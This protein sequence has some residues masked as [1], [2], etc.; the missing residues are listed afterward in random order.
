[1]GFGN[2]VQPS[3]RGTYKRLLCGDIWQQMVIALCHLIRFKIKIL[4]HFWLKYL[5]RRSCTCSHIYDQSIHLGMVDHNTDLS[6][7]KRTHTRRWY[8]C[9][10][11]CFCISRYPYN[12][13]QM[14]QDHTLKI[15]T[16]I[17]NFFKNRTLVTPLSFV[18]NRTYTRS[19]YW[20][21]LHVVAIAFLLAHN[22]K[23]TL[24]AWQF[25]VFS[26]KSSLALT[27]S[28]YRRACGGVLAIAKLHTLIAI[29]AFWTN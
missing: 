15:S 1:M 4:N 18:P 13:H 20:I 5:T 26:V 9:M 6:T 28:V 29:T 17:W 14:F 22:S 8:D 23:C 27:L 10:Y 16:K 21:T 11:H 7:Q 12:P 19:I 25:T 24:L 3:L 2:L